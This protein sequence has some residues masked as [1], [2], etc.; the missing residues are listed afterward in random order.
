MEIGLTDG[1]LQISIEEIADVITRIGNHIKKERNALCI[2]LEIINTSLKDWYDEMANKYQEWIRNDMKADSAEIDFIL[3]CLWESDRKSITEKS[4]AFLYNLDKLYRNGELKEDIRDKLD[5][6][7]IS[8]ARTS[9]N[10]FMKVAMDRKRQ[11]INQ[12]EQKEQ[13]QKSDIFN[14]ISELDNHR[15]T[16]NVYLSTTTQNLRC[17]PISRE[18]LENLRTL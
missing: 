17:Q 1:T 9:L 14:W 16:I 8:K 13:I 5:I 11:W 7:E 10:E 3:K 12:A 4:L 18:E 15:K 6:N 2:N